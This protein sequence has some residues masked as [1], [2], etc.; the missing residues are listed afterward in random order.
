[1]DKKFTDEEIED[2]KE[3]A[4]KHSKYAISNI[5]KD[6]EHVQRINMLKRVHLKVLNNMKSKNLEEE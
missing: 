5:A 4:E 1:M 2:L 6:E 3:R